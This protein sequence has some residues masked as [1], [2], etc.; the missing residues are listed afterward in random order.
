MA[1]AEKT[2]RSVLKSGKAPDAKGLKKAKAAPAEGEICYGC[3][4]LSSAANPHPVV[5]VINS[6]DLDDGW[7][8]IDNASGEPGE[9]GEQYVGVPVCGACHRDPQHRSAHPLKVHFFERKGNSAKFGIMTAGS[10]GIQ[11]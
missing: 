1:K 6:A 2:D 4:A 10:F 3:G 8:S 9:D 7:T 5:G 11:G